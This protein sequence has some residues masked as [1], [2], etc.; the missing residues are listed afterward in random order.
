[1]GQITKDG[2]IISTKEDTLKSVQDIW[3]KAF[4]PNLSLKAET[5]QGQIIAIMTDILIQIDYARQDDFYSRDL[6]KAQG[7]QLDIIGKEMGAPRKA[8]VPTQIVVSITGDTNYTLPKDVVYNMVQDASKTFMSENDI[9][10]MSN[11][12]TATLYA[13]NEAVYGDIQAGNKLQTASYYQQVS[14]IE[15][16]DV[17]QGQPAEDDTTYRA[18]L[19]SL[20]N[21]GI[22]DIANLRSKLLAINNVLDALVIQ[23]NTLEEDQY[24][25]PPHCI[26]I[27]VLG[28]NETDIAD[29]CRG[30][31]VMGTPTYLNPEGGVTITSVDSQGYTQKYNITRPDQVPVNIS[32]KYEV[33]PNQVVS[34]VDVQD[35][36]D[37][38]TKYINTRYIGSVIYKSDIAYEILNG[39]QDK[40]NLSELT[41][42]INESEVTDKYALTIRQYATAGTIEVAE[43]EI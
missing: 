33:K 4:G 24:N 22:D 9:V 28:G 13:L 6:N 10:I 27:I 29:V 39:V 19:L 15:V 20:K 17:I 30:N 16:T 18:R 14:D 34:N 40:L 41:V 23:N 7:F 32:A 26:E 1:M 5:P 3:T 8:A 35:M 11:Q 36:I 38:A 43:N 25:I 2:Y 12:Q 31:V 21:F 42:T 37:R